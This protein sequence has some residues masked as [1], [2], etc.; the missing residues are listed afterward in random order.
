MMVKNI[1]PVPLKRVV[2]ADIHNQA[3]CMLL[4]VQ[5]DLE[6]LLRQPLEPSQCGCGCCHGGGWLLPVK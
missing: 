2:L 5:P 6:A 1:D 4:A 3:Q